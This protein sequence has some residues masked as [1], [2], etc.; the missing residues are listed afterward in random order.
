MKSNLSK[1]NELN[2]VIQL[3]NE[4]MQYII[5][6]DLGPLSTS[7]LVQQSIKHFIEAKNNDITKKF[8]ELEIEREKYRKEQN[9]I[10]KK[11]FSM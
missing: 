4:N 8:E 3:I 1:D 10:S 6:Y 5:K 7:I 2:E 9:R 11:K